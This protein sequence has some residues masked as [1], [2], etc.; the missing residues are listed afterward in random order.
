MSSAG[1]IAPM[2]LPT[3]TLL[4]PAAEEPVDFNRD[5]RPLLADRCLAC[6]GPD[7]AQRKGRLRLDTA[8]GGEGAYQVIERRFGAP[9][10]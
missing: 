7:E 1:T 4:L 3:L 5:V 10:A 8:L 9:L 6:H 2:F